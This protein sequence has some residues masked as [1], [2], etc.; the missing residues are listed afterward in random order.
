MRAAL[1]VSVGAKVLGVAFALWY[2]YD[3]D[4]LFPG[5]HFPRTWALVMVVAVFTLLSLPPLRIPG[6]AF[7]FALGSGVIMFGAAN[8][9]G[10]A[11]GVAAVV[12][13]L[14]AWLASATWNRRNGAQALHSVAGLFAGAVVVFPAI[15]LILLFIEG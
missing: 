11:T 13:G 2:A 5:E 8:L 9:A 4:T 3:Q 15:G 10:E 7:L 6:G 14:V 1:I 12:C